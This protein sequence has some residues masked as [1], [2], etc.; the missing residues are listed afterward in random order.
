MRKNRSLKDIKYHHDNHKMPLLPITQHN[1]NDNNSKQSTKGI[2]LEPLKN[3]ESI[4]RKFIKRFDC[5]LEFTQ[6]ISF[7]RLEYY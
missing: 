7:K 4:P 1:V 2:H 3:K 5:K 6:P